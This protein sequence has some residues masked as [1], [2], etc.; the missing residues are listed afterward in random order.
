MGIPPNPKNTSS[1][2][3]LSPRAHK[4]ML[5]S[6]P[7]THKPFKHKAAEIAVQTDLDMR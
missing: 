4:E 3:N 1:K 6:S 2:I 5:E 7:S